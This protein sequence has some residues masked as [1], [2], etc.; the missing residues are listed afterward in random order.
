[1]VVRFSWNVHMDIIRKSFDDFVGKSSQDYSRK[2]F[3]NSHLLSAESSFEMF[4]GF[5]TKSHRIFLETFQGG[6]QEYSYQIFLEYGN[7]IISLKIFP[8]FA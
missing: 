3:L 8:E 5:K 1:M 4:K 2:S 6:V 7:R